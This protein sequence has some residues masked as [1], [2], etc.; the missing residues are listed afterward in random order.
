MNFSDIAAFIDLVKNPDKYNDALKQL[1]EREKAVK[2][3]I[4]VAGKA[5][6]IPRLHD[7]AELKL[8]KAEEEA[9]DIVVKAKTAAE[10]VLVEARLVE[11]AAIDKKAAA[12]TAF[13]QAVSAK[14][15]ADQITADYS[16]KASQLEK[17]IETQLK[18]EVEFSKQQQELNDKVAK[19][20]TLGL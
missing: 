13:N 18:K 12:D 9:K 5:Q 19:L 10:K 20:R 6:E 17:R 16:V 8:S 11:Q 2:E 3:M 1:A 15:E 4:S 14:R 7:L